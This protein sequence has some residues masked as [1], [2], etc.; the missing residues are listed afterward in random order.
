MRWSGSETHG[1]SGVHRDAELLF[2]GVAVEPGQ[3]G[4]LGSQNELYE[5]HTQRVLGNCHLSTATGRQTIK[6]QLSLRV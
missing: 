4:V 2:A 6:R 3:D 1:C 5:I